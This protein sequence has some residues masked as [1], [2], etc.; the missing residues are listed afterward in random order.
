MKKLTRTL[1]ALAAFGFAVVLFAG[2][3]A[4]LKGRVTDTAGN[5]IEG[6]TITLTTPNL[7]IFKVNLKTDKK[8]EF[9]TIVNDAT[10][11]YHLKFEKEG[12]VPSEADKKIPV[13]DVGVVD[14]KLQSTAEA[15]QAAR[16]R[17]AA[18]GPSPTEQAALVFN[19]GVDL[20]TAGKKAEAEAKF[21][22]AVGKNPDLPQGWQA[23]AV[24]AN[25][26]KAWAKTLEY[27]Q[28]ALE[29]DPSLTA[30]YG[31]LANAATQS[32][33]K[34]AAAEWEAKYAEANP[35]TPEML[36]N[37]G[38]EAYNN[39]KVKDAEAL[40]T[41]AVEAKPDF[42]IAHFWLGMASFNLNKKGAAREHLEKY[43]E[44][45]PNGAEA[46]TAK[47]ILPLVK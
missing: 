31:T 25:E 26:K 29:L 1:T 16:G 7:R 19:E 20:L 43:L 11:P 33:D 21:L 10:M 44:L 34:K 8:G 9:G 24:L 6:V 23:L 12:F 40:L 22:E 4:R 45:E 15:G 13:G 46:A 17:G 18:A 35:D 32:G 3:Q 39:K 38:V 2:A 27:G 42:A 28:K 36:Y 41:K 5:P 30:L 37:R 47:E 14:A